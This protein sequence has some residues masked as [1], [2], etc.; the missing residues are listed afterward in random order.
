MKQLLI[1]GVGDFARVAWFYFTNDSDYKVVGF[2]V[3]DAY[4][5]GGEFLG[6]PVVPYSR[7]QERFVPGECDLFVAV[8]FRRLNKARAAVF[9]TARAKGYRLATY[10]CSRAAFFGE[11]DCGENCFILENN[12]LQPFVKIADDVVL[13]SGNHIGHDAR[14]D[15][16]C[17]VSSQ[18][19]LS[20]RVHV[21]A[22][23]FL[24]VNSCVRQGVTIAPDCLVGAG[25]VI[26]RDTQ[27]GQVFVVKGTPGVTMAVPQIEGLL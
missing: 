23:C 13:W 9:A 24:G 20:G 10:I 19:V 2:T 3:D 26:L 12:V 18:V 21:G 11:V 7:V 4:V 5:G 1:F 22:R 6:L 15:D 14:L 16:H 27:P 8:G 25:A 17:F